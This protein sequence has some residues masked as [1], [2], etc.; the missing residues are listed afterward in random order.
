MVYTSYNIRFTLMFNN[1]WL[2]SAG[3][4]AGTAFR[5]LKLPF[6]H[7]KLSLHAPPEADDA[8]M[9]P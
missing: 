9:L 4:G 2:N 6:H 5:H 3:K 7:Q 8:V 1:Q